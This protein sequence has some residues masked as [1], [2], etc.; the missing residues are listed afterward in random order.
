MRN[1][2]KDTILDAAMRV[3]LR[4]GLRGWSVDLVAKEAGSSKGLVHYH[5]RTRQALLREVAA[6]LGAGHWEGRLQALDKASGAAALDRLWEALVE[7]VRSGAWAAILSL[8]TERG[9]LESMPDD[10]AR[11]KSLGAALARALDLSPP[12]PDETRLVAANLDGLELMLL[13][14]AGEAPTREAYH[15]LWL[16]VLP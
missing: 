7:E 4:E 10:S 12:L 16:A 5:H 2:L 11:L 15:R 13:G 3:L 9:L 14:G 8:R 1:G 6:R